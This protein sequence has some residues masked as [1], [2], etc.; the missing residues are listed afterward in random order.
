MAEELLGECLVLLDWLNRSVC[1]IAGTVMMEMLVSLSAS[2]PAQTQAA[3]GMGGAEERARRKW[4]ENLAK[5]RAAAF[6]AF[7]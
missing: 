6:W 4:T 5:V 7:G 3:G 1:R 2:L